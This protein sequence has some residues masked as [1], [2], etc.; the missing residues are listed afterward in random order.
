M[1]FIY[2][3][4]FISVCIGIFFIRVVIW[5]FGATYRYLPFIGL[6]FLNF[7]YF[8]GVVSYRVVA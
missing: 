2:G 5:L 3:A 6:G 1:S 4:R 7:V 8:E